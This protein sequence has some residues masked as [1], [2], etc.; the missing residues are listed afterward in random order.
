MWLPF[1]HRAPH[2]PQN[3]IGSPTQVNEPIFIHVQGCIGRSE[4]GGCVC[5]ML[6]A[7]VSGA[8]GIVAL[9]TPAHRRRLFPLC[10]IPLIPCAE[11]RSLFHLLG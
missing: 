11:R 7:A 2:A 3:H 6:D 1:Y 5:A 9:F 8:V 10:R 4:G